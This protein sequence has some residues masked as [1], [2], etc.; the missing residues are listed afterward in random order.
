[1][2]GKETDEGDHDGGRC[3]CEQK[4]HKKSE[5]KWE[6]CQEMKAQRSQNSSQTPWTAEPKGHYQE[7]NVSIQPCPQIHPIK[8]K[9]QREKRQVFPG[10]SQS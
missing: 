10:W 4:G 7:V 2:Q 5:T 3:I 6:V 8:T 1:M 9:A